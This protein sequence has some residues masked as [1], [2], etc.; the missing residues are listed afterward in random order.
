MAVDEA[1]CVALVLLLAKLS[2][3]AGA[4]LRVVMVPAEDVAVAA[5]SLAALFACLIC[6]GVGVLPVQLLA[7]DEYVIG[8]GVYE[9]GITLL[10][11]IEP[12]GCLLVHTI[13]LAIAEDPQ[14]FVAV[15]SVGLHWL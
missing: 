1:P 6:G 15:T 10:H 13:G 5:L 14:Q 2:V 11:S 12:G 7:I 8:L 3:L 9:G 4:Q